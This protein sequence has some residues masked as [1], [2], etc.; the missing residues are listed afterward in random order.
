MHGFMA[1][2]KN[3]AGH[4]VVQKSAYAM[5]KILHQFLLNEDVID[6]NGLRLAPQKTL[7][8]S[9]HGQSSQRSIVCVT[10][11]GHSGS[12]AV[13]DLL[14]EYKGVEVIGF[15]DKNGSLRKSTDLEFNLLRATGGLFSMETQYQ[16]NGAFLRGD[17]I[18]MFLR[19]VAYLHLEVGGRFNNE[20]LSVT[21]EFLDKLL[22][23][24]PNIVLGGRG[25]LCGYNGRN[26][27]SVCGT[28]GARLIWGDCGVQ[29][30]FSIRQLSVS[31]FRSFAHEY[32]WKVLDILTSEQ[33]IV[34]DQAVSDCTADIAK[35]RDYMRPLKCIAVYRDP[36]DSYATGRILKEC[37]MAYDPKGYAELLRHS[38][39]PYLKLHDKDF[40][41]LRFEDL[42]MDYERTVAE[43]EGFLG[44]SSK[45]HVF[46]KASFDPAIS[47]KNVGIYKTFCDQEAVSI[48]A[49]VIPECLYTPHEA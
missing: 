44:L 26:H 35:Y 17:A 14:S 34:L 28:A 46:P 25:R 23:P 21:R 24:S 29:R 1:K 36:R 43:I 3:L 38:L 16:D 11:F 49:K 27:L 19:L 39:E 45:A 15:V 31:E 47:A 13:V 30:V 9:A 8:P 40:L 20:F 10:G 48:V 41:M 22:V 6:T 18:R 4:G 2:Y 7:C 42:V 12:G 32:V 33:M 5:Y 37:W